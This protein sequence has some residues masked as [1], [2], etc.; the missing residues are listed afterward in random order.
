MRLGSGPRCIPPVRWKR[1]KPLVTKDE[2]FVHFKFATHLWNVH[3]ADC[4]DMTLAG[5]RDIHR[6]FNCPVGP[7]ARNFAC[8]FR[9]VPRRV[10]RPRW[11]S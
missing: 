5:L 8:R 9:F 1:N 7:V 10:P 6:Y 3:Q 4:Y 2:A 11:R